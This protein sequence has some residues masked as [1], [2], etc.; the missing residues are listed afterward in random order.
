MMPAT[1][2][3]ILRSLAGAVTMPELFG[4]KAAKLGP[5]L[6]TLGSLAEVPAALE[7]E[8][9]ALLKQVQSWVDENRG[10]TDAELDAFKADRDDLDQ[11]ARQA[12]ASL[13]PK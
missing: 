3:M 13:P 10:P 5:I 7:P 12:L 8:R 2:S 4:E 11:R 6:N 9:Q 1:V